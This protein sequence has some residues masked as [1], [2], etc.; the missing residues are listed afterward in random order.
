MTK[1]TALFLASFLFAG[2]AI[3]YPGYWKDD[4]NTEPQPAPPIINSNTGLERADILALMRKETAHT[5]TREELQAQVLSFIASGKTAW[6]DEDADSDDVIRDVQEF[7]KTY[8]PG[9]I[10]AAAAKSPA[11]A[12]ASDITFTVFTLENTALDRTGFA[13][14]CND[15]RIGTV[16]AVVEA[17]IYSIEGPQSS[18]IS[19][20]L[21]ELDAY[22]KQTIALYNAFTPADIQ[23]AVEKYER[24]RQ[25][26]YDE[27]PLAGSLTALR[28]GQGYPYNRVLISVTHSSGVLQMG[29]DIVSLAQIIAYH[30]K[31][32]APFAEVMFYRVSIDNFNDRYT[33]TRLLFEDMTFQ[34]SGMKSA[35]SADSLPLEYQQEISVLMFQIAAWAGKTWAAN[36]TGAAVDALAAQSVLNAFGY[37]GTAVDPYVGIYTG[38]YGSVNSYYSFIKPDLL[39]GSPLYAS[40]INEAADGKNAGWIIDNC[41]V[42]N[43]NAPVDYPVEYVHCIP[44]EGYNDTGWYMNSVFGS[45]GFDRPPGSPY[46]ESKLIHHIQ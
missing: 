43:A 10:A 19:L 40:V 32:P 37:R 26:D 18:F 6:I 21:S 41:Q 4:K 22:I 24:L 23:L 16:L 38:M 36:G 39:S 28:W 11:P 3:P 14:T 7:T 45:A 35:P 29:S 34:W 27:P 44:G 9:F 2:C 42:K 25:G 12:D 46:Y 13:L 20:F 17:G 5:I 33:N 8:Q 15:M 1:I 31:P 30:Q